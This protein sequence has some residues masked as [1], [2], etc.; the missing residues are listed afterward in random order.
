MTDELEKFI[1]AEIHKI[2]IDKWIFGEQIKR[3]PGREYI[4]EWIDKNAPNF[5][6]SW[7]KSKCK[8]CLNCEI[9]GYNLL[10]ACNGYIDC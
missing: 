1:K 2:D 4:L 6:Q 3:D 7:N 5:R 10:S 9:C 8:D